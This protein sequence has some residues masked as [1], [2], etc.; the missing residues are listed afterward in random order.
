MKSA[1][2]ILF[3]EAIDKHAVVNLKR[4]FRII[5][6]TCISLLLVSCSLIKKPKPT[7][8][9]LDGMTYLEG[10]QFTKGRGFILQ[11]DPKKDSTLLYNGGNQWGIYAICS[12][13]SRFYY[14]VFTF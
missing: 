7:D 4:I 11:L 14:E 3:Q 9:L 5:A 12:L 10:G 6:F 8:K 13:G 2:N 1:Q